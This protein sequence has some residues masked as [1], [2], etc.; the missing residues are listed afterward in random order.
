MLQ[1]ARERAIFRPTATLAQ[2]VEHVFRKDGVPSSNLGGGSSMHVMRYFWAPSI[3]TVLA[4]AAVAWFGGVSALVIAMLLVVLEVS[5]SFDNAVVNARVLERMSPEWQ[6]RFL[7]WGIFFAVFLTRAVLPILIVAASV[8]VNPLEIAKL[9]FFDAEQ[10]GHLLDGAHYIIAS[11]GAVFLMMVGLKYFFDDA[12]DVH[13]IAVVER[14]LSRWGRIEA[15]EIALV[16]LMLL[17]A[18]AIVPAH[19]LEILVAGLIGMVTF[20]VVQGVAGAFEMEEQEATS[21]GLALFLYLNVLDAAFSLDGVVG[22]F[23]L[24]NQL[25]VIIAG[26]GIGAYFVRSFTVYMVREKTLKSLIYLEHGAHWAILGLAAAMFM[27]LIFDVPEPITGLIG[28]LFIGLALYSSW[29][30]QQK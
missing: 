11:F 3:A 27:G 10:Y 17:G 20:I 9:A 13:W 18:A 19:A 6:Q 25:V 2:L 5:L 16:L 26:L 22:A 14:H 23:A 24:S 30:L 7:T 8:F 28:L 21:A 12:K 1:K 15:V 29:R 4:F